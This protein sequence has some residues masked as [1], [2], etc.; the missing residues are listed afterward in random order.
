MAK[1]KLHPEEVKARLRMKHGSMTA[2]ENANGLSRGA[3]CDALRGKSNRTLRLIAEA[4]GI[5]NRSIETEPK[6]GRTVKTT[7][8]FSEFHRLNDG[9]R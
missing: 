3:V 1:R 9:A 8:D 2:F 4:I 7:S 6:P 5:S